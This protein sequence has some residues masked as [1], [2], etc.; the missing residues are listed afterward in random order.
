M[1]TDFNNDGFLEVIDYFYD[2]GGQIEI[3]DLKIV[4][5]QKLKIQINLSKLA[6]IIFCHQKMGQLFLVDV[7]I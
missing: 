5:A 3:C 2:P 7:Q 4:N 6:L 1:Y